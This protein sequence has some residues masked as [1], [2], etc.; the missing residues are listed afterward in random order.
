MISPWKFCLVIPIFLE[1]FSA[2]IIMRRERKYQSLLLYP[3]C[4]GTQ[5][6]G[7]GV[8][9]CV[10]LWVIS[11]DV[12]LS[13][14]IWK[15]AIVVVLKTVWRRNILLKKVKSML[16]FIYVLSIIFRFLWDF[17]NLCER[18]LSV[19]RKPSNDILTS[20]FWCI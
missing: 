6:P 12:E 19:L 15:A 2:V 8:N 10:G 1:S 13:L 4:S 14:G 3:Y 11:C 20:D 7:C 18:K 16:T 5:L 9:L 17:I